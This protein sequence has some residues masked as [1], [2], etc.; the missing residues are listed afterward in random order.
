MP[1]RA[2]LGR[3]PGSARGLGSHPP[4]RAAYL[5]GR[6][7]R[8]SSPPRSAAP[9]TGRR[10]PRAAPRLLGRFCRP[11]PAPSYGVAM[12]TGRRPRVRR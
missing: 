1:L 2:H 6:R 11:R 4:A 8:S 10:A 9:R 12:T 5:D 7:A 3:L